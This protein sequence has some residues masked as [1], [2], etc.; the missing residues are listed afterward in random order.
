MLTKCFRNSLRA[1]A[2]P[3]LLLRLLEMAAYGFFAQ[4]E[5]RTGFSGR[6]TK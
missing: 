1:I 2:R 4:P 6:M 5:S 3:E